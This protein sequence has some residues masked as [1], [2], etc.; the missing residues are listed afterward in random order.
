[1][2]KNLDAIRDEKCF[3]IAQAILE[4]M[5]KN[6]FEEDGVKKVSL[7][8]LELTLEHD[9]NVSQEVTYIPQLI[10]GI[11]SGAN[12]T[13]QGCD[14]VALDAEKYDRVGKRILEILADAKLKM[15]IKQDK[16]EENFSGV[17]EKLSALF[18]EEKL[19]SLEVK[20]IMDNIFDKFA[21]FHNMI[22]SSIELS[23]EK[24]TAKML[25]VEN[26]SDVTMK[27]LDE[28]LKSDSV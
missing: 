28:I 3:P 12:A 13:V 14:M 7:G 10:L 6:L 25:G 24:A 5:S 16:V 9:L 23:T 22:G 17:K 19:N 26:T 1:M 15:A 2:E 20:H 18:L 11:L 4:G 21:L 27:K 8:A